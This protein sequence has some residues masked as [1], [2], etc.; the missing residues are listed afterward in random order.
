MEKRKVVI[1]LNILTSIMQRGRT[2]ARYGMLLTLVFRK[3]LA[4]GSN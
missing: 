3:V 2:V 1:N 4:D